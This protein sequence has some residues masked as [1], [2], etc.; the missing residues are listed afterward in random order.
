MKSFRYFICHR[1]ED[2]EHLTLIK[3]LRSH[4][5]PMSKG[6]FYLPTLQN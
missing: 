4:H 2:H 3:E 1:L 6:N 5:A